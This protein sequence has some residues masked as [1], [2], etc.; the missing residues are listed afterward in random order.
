MNTQDS[1]EFKV[2]GTVQTVT[3]EESTTLET[4]K[5]KEETESGSTVLA[6]IVG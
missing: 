5:E 2:V 1:I 3:I 4:V 6:L